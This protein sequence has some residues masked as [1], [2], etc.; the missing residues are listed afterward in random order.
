MEQQPVDYMKQNSEK[1]VWGK[2]IIYFL[3]HIGK[4]NLKKCWQIVSIWYSIR[5]HSLSV[6][7]NV[8]QKPEKV[9]GSV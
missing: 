1:N 9:W 2:K 3:R 4:M 8:L 7:E 6:S 5:F